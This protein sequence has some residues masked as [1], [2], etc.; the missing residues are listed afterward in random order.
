MLF[1]KSSSAPECQTLC[2]NL[3]LIR[4]PTSQTGLLPPDHAPGLKAKMGAP[5]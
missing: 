4:K 2:P 5:V 3:E 1:H